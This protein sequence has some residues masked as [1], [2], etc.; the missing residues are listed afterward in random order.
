[1]IRRKRVTKENS[2][3]VL[4]ISLKKISLFLFLF[5][6]CYWHEKTE[7]QIEAESRRKTKQRIFIENPLS[8]SFLRLLLFFFFSWLVFLI[9]W[10]TN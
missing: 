6:Y 7:K 8:S 9:S 1:M 5:Y 3:A 10:L 2:G 4:N